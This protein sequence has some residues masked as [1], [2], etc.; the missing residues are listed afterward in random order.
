MSIISNIRGKLKQELNRSMP[1]EKS[2]FTA[3]EMAIP[4]F[5]KLIEKKGQD[6]VSFGDRNLNP[7]LLADLKYG[8]AIHNAIISTAA[9]MITGDGL[10]INGAKSPEESHAKYQQLPV[11]SQKAYDFFLANP[12]NDLSTLE[13][14]QK[15][16]FDFKEQGACSYE[17]IFSSDFTNIATIKYVDVKNVRAGKMVNDV[18]KSYW[19][20]KDWENIT[21]IENKPVEIMAAD[22]NVS[23]D[24]AVKGKS[25]NQ[26][27]YIKRGSLKYYGEPDYIGGLTWIQTDFQM[28]IFHLS[29]IENGMNPSMVLKF[30]KVPATEND[31]QD[32]LE[33]IK[34]QFVGPKKTGRHMVFFSE[35]KDL[36][37][38]INPVQTSG[39]DKQ[40]LNLAELCDRKIL[41]AHK[42]T[43][44]LLAG[45][46]TS[47]QIGGNVEL[48]VGYKIY[49][50]TRMAP[51]RNQI[52]LSFNKIL[53][54]NRT[55]VVVKTN[56][57]NPFATQTSVDSNPVNTALNAL[58]PLV[59]NKVLEKMTD[60]EIRGIVG[61]KAG[62]NLPPASPTVQ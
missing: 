22:F 27:V 9:D 29:N 13:I 31:K 33:K 8:S 54:Y 18:V 45:I 6:W 24:P 16:S 38:D 43:T 26:L 7:Q 35:G 17:I 14:K 48:E 57:Y 12:N 59:A 55:G 34:K 47:G 62:A 44:P 1:K 36:S 23:K 51:Y 52:D 20:S 11:E 40:L 2:E 61:L 50:K 56:P 39:L 53:T 15:V 46:S 10:L 30:Y 37:P 41:T 19:Y 4:D 25:I 60:D 58:S 49:D 32:I 21:K 5:P 28:G 42:L 3:V